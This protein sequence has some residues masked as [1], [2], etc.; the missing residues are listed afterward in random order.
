MQ[1]R[2]LGGQHGDDLVAVAVAGGPRDAEPGR[3]HGH[4]LVLAEPDQPQQSLLHGSSAPGYRGGYHGVCARR[5]ADRPGGRRV[6]GGRRAWH[7]RRSRGV[8]VLSGILWKRD[9]LSRAPRPHQHREDHPEC[10]CR[11]QPTQL[12]AEITSLDAR[13]GRANTPQRADDRTGPGP[14]GVILCPRDLRTDHTVER[15]VKVQSSP[16]GHLPA[17]VG[18]AVHLG[19]PSAA[20]P[21]PSLRRA[22]FSVRARRRLRLS[23]VLAGGGCGVRGQA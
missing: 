23:I 13:P 10:P 12:L 20:V 15:Q 1:V 18:L 14:H 21:P 6:R 17:L 4:L 7:D 3:E 5:A 9:C 2:G 22:I 19:G 16:P 8:L 11:G